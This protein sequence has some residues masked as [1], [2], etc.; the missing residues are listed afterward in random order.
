LFELLADRIVERGHRSNA[1]GHRR[2]PLLVQGEPI[3]QRWSQ[4][5][6]PLIGKI[7]GIRF[8]D[9]PDALA[10]QARDRPQRRILGLGWRNTQRTRGAPRRRAAFGNGFRRNSHER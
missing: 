9:V 2:N 10:E 7:G 8:E 5:F 6:S 4:P 3:A 1:I